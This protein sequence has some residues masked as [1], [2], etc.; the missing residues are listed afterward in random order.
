MSSKRA[1]KNQSQRTEKNER[2][3][4]KKVATELRVQ[5]NAALL[6]NKKPER[7]SRTLRSPVWKVFDFKVLEDGTEDKSV[8]ICAHCH[9]PLSHL[10]TGTTNMISHMKAKHEDVWSTLT[11]TEGTSKS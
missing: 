11:V 8:V 9:S 1:R 10:S 4:K 3:E 2:K 5:R 6:A 7:R